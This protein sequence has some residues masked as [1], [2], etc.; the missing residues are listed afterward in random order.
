M[1]ENSE[2]EYQE[3]IN[4]E[5]KFWDERAE[6]LL[7]SGRIPLWFDHRRGEDVTFIPLNQLRGA[8]IRADPIL[9]RIVFGDMM[10]LIIKEATQKKGYAL[11]LGCGAGWLSLELARCGMNV[12]GYDISPKQ[13]EIAKNFS[14][15]SQE[16]SDPLL[17]GSFGST[18]YQVIDLNRV[19][20]E[21]EKYEV[22]VSLGTLH[23]IQRLDH[24]INE[25]HKSVKHNGKFIFYEYIGYYDLP[26]TI[27][28]IFRIA[29]ILPKFISSLLNSTDTIKSSPF[30]GI[31]Q[32]EIIEIVQ[33]RFSIQ[34]MEFRCLFSPALINRLRIYRLPHIFS[35]SLV[36]TLYFIDKS[37]I[38]LK[39]LKG[40]FVFVIAHKN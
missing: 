40:P 26:E 32:R 37:L 21:K 23:H 31:S 10:N 11:D 29:K 14:K 33:K 38:N 2:F 1:V 8:G 24:L 27:H 6:V 19:V 36:K 35:V 18:N 15:E 9:Y 3:K 28:L 7:S 13:I 4:N 39:I 5:A 20:L 17:H 34:R 25:I 30:E 12:D 16:S 22:A